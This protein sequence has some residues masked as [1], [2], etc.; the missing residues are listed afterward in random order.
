MF[1][2]YLKKAYKAFCLLVIIISTLGNS[3]QVIKMDLFRALGNSNRRNILKITMQKKMHIS[4]LAKELNISVP[5]ALKHVRILED[6]GLVERQQRGNTHVIQIK[7]EAIGR[8]DKI[9]DL[10]E[11]PLIVEIK[12]GSNMLETLKK[13]SGLKIEQTQSGAFISEVDGKKGYYIYEVNGSLP[14]KPADQYKIKGKCE[15]ELKR[16]VPVIGKK[17]IIKTG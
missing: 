13:V 1:R 15:I 2:V 11:K 9:S 5:V 7:K 14:N 17:I 3:Q 10:L 6:V 12:K 8:L 4:A 16:L